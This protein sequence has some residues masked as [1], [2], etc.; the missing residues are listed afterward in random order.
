[1]NDVILPEIVQHLSIN[2]YLALQRN[3]YIANLF[4]ALLSVFQIGIMGKGNIKIFQSSFYSQRKGRRA[5]NL[6]ISRRPLN[7]IILS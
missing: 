1:M 3:F 5:F 6:L 7:G 4:S 2:K